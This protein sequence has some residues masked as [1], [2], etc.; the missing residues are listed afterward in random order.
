MYFFPIFQLAP[1][2]KSGKHDSSSSD[3]DSSS[4]EDEDEDA[5]PRRARRKKFDV[6]KVIQSVVKDKARDKVIS[7]KIKDLIHGVDAA[8]SSKQ[9]Y[10]YWISTLMPHISDKR[11]LQYAVDIMHH[12]IREVNASQEEAEL[13]QNRPR[14]ASAPPP[15][16]R[17]SPPI[18]R[19]D[20]PLN[21]TTPPRKRPK[22]AQPTSIY[23]AS[24]PYGQNTTPPS[25][26]NVYSSNQ[27]GDNVFSNTHHNLDP[28]YG[29]FP[30]PQRPAP[31]AAQG[32]P[33]AQVSQQAAV[34]G[35]NR[36]LQGSNLVP[37]QVAPPYLQPSSRISSGSNTTVDPSGK[38]YTDL[39]PAQLSHIELLSS[40]SWQTPGPPP[41]SAVPQVSP[42]ATMEANLEILGQHIKQTTTRLV[43]VK[44]EKPEPTDTA[45][46]VEEQDDDDLGDDDIDSSAN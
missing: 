22:Q 20:Q 11:F 29:V 14:S 38:V 41:P 15:T 19:N 27:G 17:P 39:Q 40:S 12:T 37:G 5:P 10:G 28:N 8:A 32:Y 31:T 1:K 45:E 2:K 18:A 13:A 30:A 26:T 42:T 7:R 36:Q 25:P 33:Q 3:S 9:S 46:G 34:Y 43:R 44:K 4:D 24:N 21:L 6:D 23:G 16:V 35:P